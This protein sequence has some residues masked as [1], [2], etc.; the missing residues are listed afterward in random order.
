MTWILALTVLAVMAAGGWLLGLAAA[1]FVRDWRLLPIGM[2][3][4]VIVGCPFAS[5]FMS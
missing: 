4:G 2:G 3:A 1:L 5:S